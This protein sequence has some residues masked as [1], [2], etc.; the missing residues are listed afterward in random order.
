MGVVPSLIDNIFEINVIFH[1]YDEVYDDHHIRTENPTY[2]NSNGPI[3]HINTDCAKD[4]FKDFS[5]L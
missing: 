5:H 1:N 4:T 2:D 3:G